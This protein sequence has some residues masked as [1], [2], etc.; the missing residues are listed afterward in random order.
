MTV[1]SFNHSLSWANSGVEHAQAYRAK[2]FQK[3]GITSKFIFSKMVTENI[4]HL[5]KNMGFAP[6]QILWVY[7][8]LTD[9]PLSLPTYPMADFVA[10]LPETMIEV[11]RDDNMVVFEN[12]QKTLRIEAVYYKENPG[13]V[14]FVN[15]IGGGKLAR[16]EF[17]SSK[18]Q[19]AEDYAVVDDASKVVKRTFFNQDGSVAFIENDGED[20]RKVYTFPEDHYVCVGHNALLRRF[21]EKNPMTSRDILLLDRDDG[22]E[23]LLFECGKPAKLAIVIHADHYSQEF[24]TQDNILWNNFYEHQ[25]QHPEKVDVYIASTDLQSDLFH[26]QMLDYNQVDIKTR[27]IPVG[28]LDKLRQPDGERKPFSLMT[29]SR[30]A[31]EKHIDHLVRAVVEA[32]KTLPELIFDIYGAG[33]EAPRIQEVINE[34][35]ANDYIRL[36][37]YQTMTEIYKDYEVYLTA[38]TSEGFGL[39]LLEAVGSGLPII[40]YD[41]PYGNPTFVRHGENG[42][43]IPHQA[44]DEEKILVKRLADAIITYFTESDH[45]HARD[46]SYSIAEGYLDEHLEDNWVG[47]VKEMLDDTTI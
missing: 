30:L 31:P 45:A 6:E 22:E 23:Q 4:V 18:K 27:T 15:Y 41:V 21:F 43:L 24:T 5:G 11:S 34:L 1:Y 42:F 32:R 28:S 36:M 9:L 29:A 20:A 13:S 40:G 38:S 2:I 39:T 3:R 14:H 44:I 37:G 46:V 33:E 26:Q 8:A 12:E 19:Y 25:F 10:Q 47:F 35:G 16:K 7:A 17:Y